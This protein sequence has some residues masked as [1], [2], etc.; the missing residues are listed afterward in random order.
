[1]L[2]TFICNY[3]LS[4]NSAFLQGA[5][6]L[7]IVQ[8]RILKEIISTDY[9][10]I[11][12]QEVRVQVDRAYDSTGLMTTSLRNGEEMQIITKKNESQDKLH[13]FMA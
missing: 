5:S 6:V 13:L 10:V 11:V 9:A 8:E 4:E 12:T 7:S 2:H 3:N 1:M